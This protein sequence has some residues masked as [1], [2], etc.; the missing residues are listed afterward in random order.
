MATGHSRA[1]RPRVRIR[2]PDVALRALG[3]ERRQP[4]TYIDE[5]RD[6][7]GRA[8]ASTE[9]AHHVDV[10]ADRRLIPTETPRHHQRAQAGF[11]QRLDDLVRQSSLL[12]G[13]L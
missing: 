13:F 2:L 5:A 12:V 1:R 11:L 9:L 10:G 8:A 4:G 3:K 7:R 6:P